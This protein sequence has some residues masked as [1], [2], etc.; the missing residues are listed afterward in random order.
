MIKNIVFDFG[1]VLVD[2]TPDKG[3][4]LM[5]FSEEQIRHFK[6]KIYSGAWE[7]YDS[8]MCTYEQVI[9]EFIELVPEHEDEV[10]VLW[11][12]MELLTEQREYATG[13]ISE[14]KAMGYNVYGLSNFG[15]VAW[16]KCKVKYDF[17]DMLDGYVI[18]AFEQCA[19]P[20]RKIY[21]RLLDRFNLV[22]AECLFVDDRLSNVEAAKGLGMLGVVFNSYEQARDEIIRICSEFV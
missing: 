9:K 16:E 4:K 1:L 7:E 17:V 12:K 22:A 18:S 2:W 6:E 11:D 15:N 20:D 3:M 10:K 13:W 14:L 21:E 8:R 5:G 19:K